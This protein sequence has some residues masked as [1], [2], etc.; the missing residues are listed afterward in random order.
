M[1]L[2]G[3]DRVQNMLGGL[4]PDDN[5]PIE[6]GLISKQIE[7]AQKK[8]EARNFEIRKNVLSYDDVINR[9]RHIIYDQR[10]TV[11]EGEDIKKN[12]MDMLETVIDEG[13]PLYC[14]PGTY[15]EEW[16]IDGLERHFS[17]IFL[18]KDFQ[19]IDRTKIENYESKD[20][21]KSI[22][23]LAIDLYSKKE[24]SFLEQGADMRE[25]ERYVLLKTVDNKWMD[26]IDMMDQL[27]DGI[28]LRAYGQRDPV[29][30]FRNEGF[31]MF[32]DMVRSIQSDTL[33]LLFFGVMLK[34]SDRAHDE[35][36]KK[37]GDA[38]SNSPAK[39]KPT[40]GR[41][42]PCP[43]GSGKKYKNCCGKN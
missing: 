13:L 25:I 20:L 37:Y 19:L 21:I 35:K 27:K 26:H 6:I 16:D 32:D 38:P 11:L 14:P 22:K 28:R 17:D 29:V 36:V 42:A 9:Q 7:N 24:A 18:P 30:E 40:S 2:F 39:A 8:I 1:R 15:P 43:C 5:V 23:K 31:D 10:K 4:N 34:D 12:I 3:G 33:R 41:N